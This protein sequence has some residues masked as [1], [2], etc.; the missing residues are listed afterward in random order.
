MRKVAVGIIKKNNKYLACQRSPYKKLA[1]MWEFP[2]GKLEEHE[3]SEEALIRELREELNVE[4]INIR[5]Y[6]NITHTYE[7]GTF[8]LD[9]YFC[10]IFDDSTIMLNEE[11]QA[12]N[13]F[14]KDELL[15]LNFVSS[16][17]DIIK[18]FKD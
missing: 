14:T 4:V 2:G 1:N 10:D 8:N 9:F 12:Y 7:H 18:S 6:K 16:A 15:K 17:I 11:N 13:W 5:L 3:T